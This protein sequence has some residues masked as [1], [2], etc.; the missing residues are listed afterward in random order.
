MTG[1]E[2][3]GPSACSRLCGL[4]L[5]ISMIAV[6]TLSAGCQVMNQF[7]RAPVSQPVMVAA[8]QS[9]DDLIAGLNL[10]SARVRQVK[11]SVRVAAAG[12]PG[13]RGDLLVERPNRLRLQAGL[14]GMTDAGFD[15]GSND[16]AFW[17]WQKISTPGQ[18]ETFYFARHLDYQHSQLKQ[19]LQMQPLWLV[20]G[21]GLVEFSP[22][23]KHEGPVLRSDGRIE[24]KSYSTGTGS[25]DARKVVV[26]PRTLE[27][28]QIA[29]YD[30]QLRCVGWI[31]SIEYE[32]YDEYET[33]LPRR[34]EIHVTPPDGQPMQLT[35]QASKY[36]INSIYGDPDRLWQM[37][38]AEGVRQIDL[39]QGIA[40]DPV[41][42][43]SDRQALRSESPWILR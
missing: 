14:M 1:T 26:D 35:V 7:R 30:R 41:I 6:L 39:S 8:P 2:S 12:T 38:R 27:V 20:D 19:Q 29:Y 42:G 31:N 28:Q 10:R 33:S 16:E 36:S 13:L 11:T 25:F 15:L 4:A 34:I 17:I 32:R 23:D 5:S 37:P 3:K 18:P 22:T 9:L 40:M 24:I 43:T 21:L